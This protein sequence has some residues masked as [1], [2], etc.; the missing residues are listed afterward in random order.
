MPR[1][2]KINILNFKLTFLQKLQKSYNLYDITYD[3]RDEIV[4]ILEFTVY[5]IFEI[6]REN[7]PYGIN[8]YQENRRSHERDEFIKSKNQRT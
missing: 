5:M 2:F 1:N 7:S 6:Y 8:H 3:I 4:E